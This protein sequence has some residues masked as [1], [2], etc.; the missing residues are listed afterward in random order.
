M[1]GYVI[2]PAV[3]VLVSL[4]FTSYKTKKQQTTCAECCEKIELLD[5][6]LADA[7][8][9]TLKRMLVTVSPIAKAVQQLQ[10]TVG[11]Q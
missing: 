11:I 3:A 6:R 1:I 5:K 4:S 8:A 2:G 7:D 10:E 9:E